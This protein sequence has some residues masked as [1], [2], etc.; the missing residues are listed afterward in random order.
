MNSSSHTFYRACILGTSLAAMIAPAAHAQEGESLDELV[1]KSLTNMQN[2]KWA[3]ALEQLNKAC[4]KPNLKALYGAKIGVLYYRKGICESKLNQFDAAMKSFETCYRDFPPDADGAGN[5]YHKLALLKWGDAALGAEQ[6]DLAIR[7][8]KKFLEERSTERGKDQYQKGVFHINLCICY[9]KL[10]KLPEGMENLEIAIKNKEI[11][12]TPD[13]GI[14]AGFQAFVTA[15]IDKANEQALLDFMNKNRADI[16]IEPFEMQEFNRLFMKLAHDAYSANMERAS[17]VLYQ[18]VSATEVTLDDVKVRLASIGKRKGVM[19]GTRSISADKLKAAE[20]AVTTAS[21]ESKNPEITQLLSMAYIHEINGNVRGAFAAYEN[22]ELYYPKHE[23]REN[24]LFQLVRTSSVVGEVLITEKYG[25]IF[26]KAF[27]TS[28]HVPAVRRMMLTSLFYEGEYKKCIEV[29]VTLIDKLEKGSEQHDICLHVLGGSYYYEGEYEKAQPYLDRHVAEY[30]KSKFVQAALFFQASNLVK[31]QDFAKAAG[32]LDSFLKA[33]P[34]SGKNPYL[35]FA[36]F[37]RATCHYAEDEYAPALA[38]I[39]RLEKEFPQTE[40]LDLA[41]NLKGNVHL[42]EKRRDEAETYYKKGFELAERRGVKMV[43]GESVYLLIAML[44]EKSTPKEPNPRI[45]DA[46]PWIDKYWKEYADGSPYRTQAAVAGI[47]AM[48]AVER[49]DEG[50][51][52]L[53]D[54]IAEMAGDPMAQGLEEAIGSYTEF[55]LTKHSPEELKEHYYNF[56]KIKAK[57]TVA[58][59]LLRMAVIGVFEEQL[60]NAK[61]PAD[62]SQAEARVKVLF[63]ELKAEFTP[64]D[65]TS[66]ILVRVGDFVREK[67]GAP[68]EA[69]DYYTEALNRKNGGYRAEALFGRADVLGRSK[70]PA[71]LD[72]AIKDLEEVFGIAEK[73]AQKDKALYRKIELLGAKGEWSKVNE[74]AKAYLDPKKNNFSLYKGEVTMLMA[75]SYE[76]T[77]Q[78]NDAI[79]SYSSI[80]NGNQRG[81]IKFSAPACKRWMELL[82]ERDM[83]AVGGNAPDRQGAYNGGFSYVDSTSRLVEKM[84]QEEKDMWNAVQDLV[85]DYEARPGIKSVAQQKKEAEAK[86]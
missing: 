40:V 15:C 77:N 63:N 14:V 2:N 62:R 43:A 72:T 38:N 13:A 60:K 31:L 53:R 39:D 8:Y 10:G 7:Q 27:P 20:T 59:A 52:R 65:L 11:F 55:Y 86:K 71:D 82:W 17:I 26:L 68:R 6:F 22:L 1:S 66:F 85:K 9:F 81:A 83:A 25:Q 48:D 75:Q 57:D 36:L 54:V 49:G 19:D 12:P 4:A 41:F 58:R 61:E 74:E 80:F 23:K 33:Y 51:D 70:S 21:R 73:K 78:I 56:P 34:E 47:Y 67:T 32:L 35:P 30:P 16:I 76:K 28:E 79:F 18:M 84:T 42:A 37:D 45:K 5:I 44:G 64:K 69:L 24:N 3:E 29:A 46:V 50:L